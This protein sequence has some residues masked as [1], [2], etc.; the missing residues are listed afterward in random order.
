MNLLDLARQKDEFGQLAA[1]DF[2][3]ARKDMVDHRGAVLL[4]W[5]RLI[6]VES[7]EGVFETGEIDGA[8]TRSLVQ[9][10]IPVATEIDPEAPKH[11]GCSRYGSGDLTDLACEK[12]LESGDIGHVGSF[13]Y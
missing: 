3:V 1:V 10:D 6:G 12:R 4:G 11:A 9:P 8:P 2:V 7:A 13:N 5:Q